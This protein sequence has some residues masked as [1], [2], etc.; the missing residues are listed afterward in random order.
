MGKWLRRGIGVL[1]F[2]TAMVV[3][4]PAVLN[5]QSGH[6]VVNAPVLSVHSPISGTLQDFNATAGQAVSPGAR[7]GRVLSLRARESL[8]NELSSLQERLQGLQSQQADWQRLQRTFE[9]RAKL[10]A[11]HEMARLQAQLAE[12]DSQARA[13]QAQVRQDADT[14]ARQE[15]LASENF[16][17]PLQIDAARNALQAS[18]AQL[19]A[20]QA[21]EKMLRIEG[22]AVRDQVYLGQGR[23]DVPYSQQKLE[24]LRIQLAELQTRLRETHS[25]VQQIQ[26]QLAQGGDG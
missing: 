15:R 20:I 18:Q 21:R 19:E 22:V 9:R 25:R 2:M 6:A 8:E 1:I 23:N 26:N 13:Q 24:D 7:L 16:I 17:S 3:A 11:N 5:Q 4:V 10:H 14:L 12:V